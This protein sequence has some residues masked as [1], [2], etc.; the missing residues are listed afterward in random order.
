[1]CV[2]ACCASPT[3][4]PCAAAGNLWTNA[5]LMQLFLLLPLA[6]L[7]LAPRRRGFRGRVAAAAAVVTAAS[8][9]WRAQRAAAQGPAMRLPVADA[10]M[11]PCGSRRSA[12]Q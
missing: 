4:L 2:P 8:M 11:R 10:A 3:H 9:A 12:R 5:L 1:M 7:A 6:L